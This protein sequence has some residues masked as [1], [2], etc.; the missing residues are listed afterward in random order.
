MRER[1]I[2]AEFVADA[3]ESTG[4]VRVPG[5][6]PPEFPERFGEGSRQA[7]IP[8]EALDPDRVMAEEP[9]ISRGIRRAFSVPDATIDPWRPVNRL[10]DYV[11]RRRGRVLARRAVN[12][13][14]PTGW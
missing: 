1:R 10:G 2:V 11:N 5:E 9:A 12:R 8:C 7:D 4:P 3:V 6:A 14:W 13:S